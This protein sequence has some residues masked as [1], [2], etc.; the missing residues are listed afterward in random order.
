MAAAQGQDGARARGSVAAGVQRWEVGDTLGE[1]GRMHSIQELQAWAV[2]WQV[3]LTVC[4][5]R[6]TSKTRTALAA[7]TLRLFL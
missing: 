5:W 1:Q 4:H 6:R 3:G 7:A 2:G